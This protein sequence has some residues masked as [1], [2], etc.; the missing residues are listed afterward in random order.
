MSETSTLIGYS[1]R[2]IGRE[3]PALVPTPPATETHRPIPH[4]EIIG[5]LIET[6]G[7][8][9]IGVAHD[10]Y[11]VSPDGQ[12]FLMLKA[13]DKAEAAPTQIN[14]VLN[15]FEELKQKVPTGKK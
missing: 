8:R 13:N 12:R 5:A 2:T 11:A 15:W 6:L 4:H 7:F 14:V 9:H 10:E 1:G 3:E